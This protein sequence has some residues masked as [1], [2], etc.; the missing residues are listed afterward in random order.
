MGRAVRPCCGGPP[1][2]VMENT[3]SDA[4]PPLRGDVKTSLYFN[5][6]LASDRHSRLPP[7]KQR[8]TD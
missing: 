8:W 2:R 5:W 3:L 1:W 6:G 4:S 7:P